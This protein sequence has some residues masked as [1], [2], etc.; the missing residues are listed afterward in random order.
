MKM[1]SGLILST[2]MLLFIAGCS[3]LQKRTCLQSAAF[4]HGYQA[5]SVMTLMSTPPLCI[6]MI[7]RPVGPREN[8]NTV[9]LQ[10]M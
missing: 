8:E 7:L 5:K 9:P 2:I 4:Q 3:G 10:I 6:A 1:L